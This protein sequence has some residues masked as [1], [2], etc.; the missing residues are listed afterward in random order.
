MKN[1]TTIDIDIELNGYDDE[2]GVVID[3]RVDYLRD[4]IFA[5]INAFGGLPQIG[6]SFWDGN[7]GV[8]LF[9]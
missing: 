6:T 3:N 8:K 4:S 5:F 2:S 1:E 9:D 7:M